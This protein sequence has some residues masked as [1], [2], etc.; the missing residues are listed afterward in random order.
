MN[1][2]RKTALN[3]IQGIFID[4]FGLDRKASLVTIIIVV[5][6]MILAFLW[7][8]LSAPPKTITITSGEKGSLYYSVAE[9]YA[10]ILARD[11]VK[12]IILPSAGSA[13]NLKR[14]ADPS[15]KV[16]IGF[17]Q[18]GLAKGQNIERLVSLGSVS[19]QPLLIFHRL[20]KA[21]EVLSQM[22]GKRIAVGREGTGTRLLALTLLSA[23]GI[24]PGG[25]TTLLEAEGEEAAAAL[26]AGKVDV[27][28][29][30]ADSASSQ[31]MRSLLRTPGIQLVDFVQADGYMR[32]IGYLNK[33]VMPRGAM[34]FGKDIPAR[35]VT[36]ISPTVEMIAR[37][38]LHPALSDLLLAAAIEIHGRAA[39]FQ[40]R[41]EFPAALEN[42]YKVSDDAKRFYKSGKTFFYRYLPF[43]LAS[44]INRIL[45]VFVPLIIILIPGLKSIPA[46]FRW[47]MRLRIN[48]WYRLLLL[49]E[50]DA[51]ARLS[52][53]TLETLTR[54]IDEIESEVNK[55]K[56]PASYGDQFYVLRSNIQF[57]RSK[58]RDSKKAL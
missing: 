52:P 5:L 13:E 57:V 27:I 30:M 19:Y 31:T 3:K 49:A 40:N 8:F 15:F 33:L 48:R 44:L 25:A 7:F 29:L 17:V 21:V 28:F 11:G 35:D 37:D 24:E 46:L 43:W 42:E 54:R 47:R 56:V 36:L 23:N 9:K 18:A 50:Q 55:M 34:D 45:V 26:K 38:R 6:V 1:A 20:P 14:L 4:N 22:A 12:L 41:G 32:R 39:L 2:T 10:K 53:E 58:F 51:M 16:D